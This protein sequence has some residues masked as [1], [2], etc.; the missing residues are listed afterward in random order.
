MPPVDV[1]A[2][3]AA[4]TS[5]LLA[6]WIAAPHV[7]PWWRDEPSPRRRRGDLRARRWTAH[8]PTEVFIVEIDGRAVGYVQR[9]LLDDYPAWRVATRDRAERRDRL[10][11]RRGARADRR[12][13]GPRRRR[14]LH[15]RHL[16]ALPQRRPAWRWRCSRPTAARGGRS[17][18]PGSRASSPGPSTPTTPATR[19]RAT[20]TSGADRRR[21]GPDLGDQATPGRT[22]WPGRF[23]GQH[24]AVAHDGDAVDDGPVHAPGPGL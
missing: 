12:R 6:R 14:P 2:A 19:G 22:T 21:R 15:H 8:D 7:A 13:R 16:R 18:R 1:P 10:P 3:H 11:D 17:R 9:Y 5:A 20:S 4:T 24:L 23:V